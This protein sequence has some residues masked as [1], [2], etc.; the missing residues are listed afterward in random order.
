MRSLG[1]RAREVARAW[2]RRARAVTQEQVVVVLAAL[3]CLAFV[4]GLRDVGWRM[5]PGVEIPAPALPA[6]VGERDADLT[7]V[8][9]DERDQAIA[10]ASVR[11]F[12]LQAG[13]AYFAGEQPTKAGGRAVFAALP[14]GEAWVLA[15]GPGRSRASLRA[16]LEKG[17]RE[18]KLVLH[19]AKALD[20]VVVDEGDKP[21]AGARVEV[22]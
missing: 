14:R 16:V 3:V 12:S 18:E 22:R 21:V 9:V 8:V 6:G 13:T 20:V 19:P 7:A 1:A 10:G 4:A 2:A 5:L 17:P 11:V 15:Y